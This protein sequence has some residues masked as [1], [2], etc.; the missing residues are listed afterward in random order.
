MLQRNVQIG[1]HLR[2][3]G[4]P[5]RKRDE[6]RARKTVH[7]ANPRDIG[8]SI[9]E[10]VQELRQANAAA[11]VPTIARRILGDQVDLLHAAI[12]Q[13][14]GVGQNCLGPTAHAWAFDERYRAEGAR[15]VAAVRQLEV[16]AG[17]LN[18]HARKVP[19]GMGRL[20]ARLVDDRRPQVLALRPTPFQGPN[21]W[22]DVHPAAGANQ[23]IDARYRCRDLVGRALSV[24]ASGNQEL[25]G[26]LLGRQLAQ[27]RQRLLARGVNESASID[28]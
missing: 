5:V 13:P 12:R 10:R 26:L 7:D 21:E 20:A 19:H 18:G 4:H 27:R 16:G 17:T 3:A 11:Q 6:A 14:C 28:D 2:K 25:P 15:P 1:K 24:A 9:D 22:D 8:H 23:S